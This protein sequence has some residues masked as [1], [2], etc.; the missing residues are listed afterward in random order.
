MNQ[1]TQN[2]IQFND[3]AVVNA[4][5]IFTMITTNDKYFDGGKAAVAVIDFYGN[6]GNTRVFMRCRRS[7]YYYM[8]L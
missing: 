4:I 6:G 3:P 5:D 8:H 2:E 7:Y 1:L